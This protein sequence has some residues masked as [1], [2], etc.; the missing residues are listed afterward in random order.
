MTR[1][2][3]EAV[4]ARVPGLN[5]EGVGLSS[6]HGKLTHD[7]RAALLTSN[8]EALLN[9][10]ADCAKVTAWLATVEKAKT[11]NNRRDSYGLKHVMEAETGEYV[12]NGVFIAAAIHAGF[13][14]WVEAGSINVPLGIAER[15]LKGRRT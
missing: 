7:E 9:S 10:G 2:E 5:D 3:I 6:A 1:A 11:V 13:P 8:R 12:S 15:S 4:I 14:Y